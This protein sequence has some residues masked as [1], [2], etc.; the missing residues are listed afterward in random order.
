MTRQRRGQKVRP[1]RDQAA[2]CERVRELLAR[3]T[4]LLY[5][6]GHPRAEEVAGLIDAFDTNAP[7]AWRALDGNAWWAGAGS[8][9][10]ESMVEPARLPSSERALAMQE[11]R[12]L[13]IDLAELLRERGPTNPGLSSWL[14]AFRNW[15]A[16]GV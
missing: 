9:A 8:L 4:E 12:A 11:F 6:I 13:L 14:L 7:A 3:L 15:E 2:D 5:R 1:E 16:S 10:A